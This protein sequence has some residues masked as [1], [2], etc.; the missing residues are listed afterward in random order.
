VQR[1]H[2]INS[3]KV[4]AMIERRRKTPQRPFRDCEQQ[5]G[6]VIQTQPKARLRTAGQA[7]KARWASDADGR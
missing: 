4:R 2:A 6:N 1:F 3:P 7:L 5:N